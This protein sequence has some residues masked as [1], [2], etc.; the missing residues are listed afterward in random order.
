[1]Q[2]KF[3]WRGGYQGTVWFDSYFTGGG[4]LEL[5]TGL[6]DYER[7]QLNYTPDDLERDVVGAIGLL[8]WQTG[9]EPVSQEL[10]DAF[11]DWRLAEHEN[12]IAAMD[13]APERYG[14]T[15]DDP[16]RYPPMLAWAGGQYVVGEGWRITAR[17]RLTTLAE[18]RGRA[19]YEADIRRRPVYPN[20]QQR[21]AWGNLGELARETWRKPYLGALA[22]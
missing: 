18:V 6:D 15:P 5:R 16:L 3:K 11:N 20:G 4:T 10:L 1:M 22:A 9:I 13:A 19:D 7:G 17:S 14:L 2:S 8:R 21:C 12:A